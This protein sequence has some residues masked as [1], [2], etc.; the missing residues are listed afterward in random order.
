[1][2]ETRS[3]REPAAVPGA[4]WIPL[5][6]GMFALVDDYAKKKAGAVCA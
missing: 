3:T 4:R 2:N 5:T 6:R 1:M